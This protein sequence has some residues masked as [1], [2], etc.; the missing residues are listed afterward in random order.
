MTD[1]TD[2]VDDLSPC[3]A[4][5]EYAARWHWE[6]TI[7]AT[8]THADGHWH[9]SCRS[10]RCPGAGAHPLHLD[11]RAHLS[12]TPQRIREWWSH[13]PHASVVLATGRGFDVL[14]VPEQ[15]GCLALVRLER[16]GVT[17]GP[18]LATPDRRIQFLVRPG[19]RRDL[20]HLLS[21]SGWRPARVDLRCYS[22]AGYVLA[23]PSL[24]CP[25]GSST[26]G[27]VHWAR[28]PT[29]DNQWLPEAGDLV[30][31]LAYACA[32]EPGHTAA[33][34]RP[35]ASAAST[36]MGRTA[37]RGPAGF[38]HRRPRPRSTCQ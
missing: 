22:D 24:L 14:D 27:A 11:W 28:R 7:G 18:V 25:V 4:A 3:E 13:W 19:T 29:H 36:P 21:R 37:A 34:R 15:A 32:R 8:A 10:P 2:S 30:P 35:A 5:L 26:V 16:R 1:K 17:L 31:T 6:V 23:P 38:P 9:C 20:P 12:R 33:T